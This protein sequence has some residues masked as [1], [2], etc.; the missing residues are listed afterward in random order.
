[1]AEENISY[2]YIGQIKAT[3]DG[4]EES[5][6]VEDIVKTPTTITMNNITQVYGRNIILDA[7]VTDNKNIGVNIGEVLFEIKKIDED[8]SQY[9]T[10]GYSTNNDNGKFT[11]NIE[12]ISS[13]YE[14]S[15]NIRATYIQNRY[16]KESTITDVVLK[17]K[18]LDIEILINDTNNEYKI[19]NNILNKYVKPNHVV[20]I[21]FNINLLDNGNIV[22]SDVNKISNEEISFII[23]D[24]EYKTNIIDNIAQ[25]SFNSND[26]GDIDKLETMIVKVSFKG[27]S[28]YISCNKISYINTSMTEKLLFDYINIIISPLNTNI[29]IKDIYSKYNQ[30]T[31]IGANIIDE[32]A[33]NVKFGNV[34]YT[35]TKDVDIITDGVT[36]TQKQTIETGEGKVQDGYFY[37]ITSIKDDITNTEQS[38]IIEL[39]DLIPTKIELTISPSTT[40]SANSN[41]VYTAH[42]YNS[43]DNTINITEGVVIFLMD[44]IIQKTVELNEDGIATYQDTLTSKATHKIKAIYKGIFEYNSSESDVQNLTVGD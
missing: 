11:Y 27:T 4:Q 3:I 5:I 39:P 19:E 33:V 18:K 32:N 38:D 37:V 23:D 41:V 15:Y 2:Q 14:G 40:V 6:G 43:G 34:I 24:V 12:N 30:Q 31:Y 26:I 7:I 21:S 9:K 42:V 10:L 22:D 13:Y 25:Y 29:K 17:I 28:Q 44:D 20:D 16:Y 36:T 8:V 35:I 1:M